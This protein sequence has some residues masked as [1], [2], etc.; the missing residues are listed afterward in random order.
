VKVLGIIAEYNPFHN[1]H[2]YHLTESKKISGADVT[3]AIM[4]GNFVQRGEAALFSKWE[5]AKIAVDCGVDL[6][7]E[8][9]FV[10]AC[11]SAE[12]FAKGAV[13]ILDGISCVDV[14]SFGSE[15]GN[16]DK[17]KQVA[18]LIS[19]ETEEFK[20]NI[21]ESLDK[22]NSFPKARA[23]AISK[24]SG[25]DVAEIIGHPNNILAVEYIRELINLNSDIEP[26][27]VPRKGQGDNSMI[28]ANDFASA[29]GIRKN[30]EEYNDINKILGYVPDICFQNM[31]N[32]G[33]N[34]SEKTEK[35]F[36]LLCAGI[37]SKSEN[38]LESMV[39]AG[40]GLGN[41]MK[42]VVRNSKNLE[43]LISGVKSKRY[44]RTR[45]TRLLTHTL[46]EFKIIELKAIL[47]K[48]R[49]YTRVL[50]F[51]DKG[52]ALLKRIKE[53]E[54]MIPVITNINKQI[55]PDDEIEL[56]LKYD[57]LATD[58]YNLIS[59]QKINENSDFV[60]VPYFC[61]VEK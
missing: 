9:P 49:N 54:P 29:T 5:R 14:I 36:L 6:V 58:I 52:A 39:S 26:I 57:I 22:G 34:I 28:L 23:E 53:S 27:T 40:E 55:N 16:L 10:Y 48:K 20:A 33:I 46:L 3:V 24:I 4:S 21:K 17:L 11:N 47:D 31:K 7:L 2:F 37:L 61:S 60:K 59:G 42:K 8:L 30:L 13:Q 56:L 44:T 25:E 18:Q 38:D 15:A 51:N 45:I 1:G 19:L 35:L 12:Y 43:E 32:F 41:K 50:A